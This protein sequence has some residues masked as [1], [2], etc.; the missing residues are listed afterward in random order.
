MKGTFAN[1]WTETRKILSKGEVLLR[2]VIQGY[3]TY[4]ETHPPQDPTVGICIGF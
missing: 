3:L 1:T 4:K 2:Q